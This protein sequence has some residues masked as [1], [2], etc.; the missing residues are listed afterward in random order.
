M[1]NTVYE[2]TTRTIQGRYLLRPSAQLRRRM[3]GV[4]CAAQALYP[5]VELYAFAVLSNHWE[6]LASCVCAEDFSRY[7]GYVNSNFAR[8]CGR[9]N[10]W[11]GPFW[12]RRVRM[13]PCL[14]DASTIDRLRYCMAQGAK[15]GLVA[16]P[17]EWPGATAVPALVGDMTLVGEQ[18]DRDALRRARVAAH[19]REG[20]DDII[21]E[22]DFTRETRLQLTPLPI[23]RNLDESA[24]RARH[25]ELLDSIVSFAAIERAGRPP[26]GVEAILHQEPHAA[27][28]DFMPT[29]A[30]ACHTSS[31]LT[32]QAFQR[33]RVAFTAAYRSVADAIAKV[34][35]PRV[36]LPAV[37]AAAFPTSSETHFTIHSTIT[38]LGKPNSLGESTSLVEL[39]RLVPPGMF[40]QPR[41]IHRAKYIL[42]D[43]LSTLRITDRI[44]AT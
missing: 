13:I 10:A 9:A 36:P 16:S 31:T 30:P 2:C 5:S 25:N 22:A 11:A 8:E 27:P 7:A 12:G 35:A 28:L 38:S 43:D 44:P 29:A 41:F 33:L 15:E 40:L 3:I 21:C 6:F 39:Q 42:L 20:G 24:L 34:L 23:F 37:P 18:L 17:L 32:R 1:P 4:L 14:D 19:R 26:L